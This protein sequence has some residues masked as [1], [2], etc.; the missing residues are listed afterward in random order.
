MAK[1]ITHPQDLENIKTLDSVKVTYF[2]DDDF[3]TPLTSEGAFA[4]NF[5][6]NN[7]KYFVVSKIKESVQFPNKLSLASGI[8]KIKDN[9]IIHSI[10]GHFEFSEKDDHSLEE[11]LKRHVRI[12]SNYKTRQLNTNKQNN[13]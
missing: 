5:Q 10:G 13:Y 2:Y 11:T 12:L 7:E 8:Y 1:K 6:L 9:S 4:G 3:E